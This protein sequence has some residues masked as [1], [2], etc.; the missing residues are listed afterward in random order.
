[1]QTGRGEVCRHD[2]GHVSHILTDYA[3]LI[4]CLLYGKH[5]KSNSFNV[6]DTLLANGDELNLN[7]QSLFF[8]LFC[9]HQAFWH[10]H[11]TNIFRIKQSTF[12]YFGLQFS[13]RKM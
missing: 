2:R 6:T 9:F 13:H 10:S 11:N 3:R 4:R 7:L 12:L 5:E 8:L 1:M